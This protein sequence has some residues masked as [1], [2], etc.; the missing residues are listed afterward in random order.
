[1]KNPKK[2]I[3]P[4]KEWT[5]H[6]YLVAAARKTWRWAPQHKLVLARAQVEKGSW[7][8]E[9]C[10]KVVT[11]I[12]YLTK[13][14]RK[15]RKIDGAVDHITPIG[16]QPKNWAE[17]PMFYALVFCAIENLM[18]LCTACHSVKSAKEAAE[19]KLE[20]ERLKNGPVS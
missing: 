10:S 20:R 11:R 5:P 4:K 14:G 2:S 17:Y 18:F 1:M 13:R 8:C 3:K 6:K 19:R 16:K 9:K 7:K 12:N 15:A